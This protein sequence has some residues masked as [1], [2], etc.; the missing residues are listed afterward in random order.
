MGIRDGLIGRRNEN[1]GEMY[2]YMPV[3]FFLGFWLAFFFFFFL[4]MTVL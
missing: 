4:W 1:G 2:L 3:S